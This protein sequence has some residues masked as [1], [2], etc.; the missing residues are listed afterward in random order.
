MEPM[1]F[2][3]ILL[4]SNEYVFFYFFFRAGTYRMLIFVHIKANLALSNKHSYL[5]N[6]P[7]KW[8]DLWYIYLHTWFI[9]MVNVR[10]LG[11]S[12]IYTW[13]LRIIFQSPVMGFRFFF[14]SGFF[15]PSGFR[16]SF[17]CKLWAQSG[18]EGPQTLLESFE[19]GLGPNKY[20]LYKD[21]QAV[22]VPSQGF[23][24]HFPGS[25]GSGVVA[26]FEHCHGSQ[27]GF[28]KTVEPSGG[29]KKKMSNVKCHGKCL[30]KNA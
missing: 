29:R 16:E 4:G 2:I 12:R 17:C 6:A 24:H 22:W 7:L 23:S 11:I 18:D 21:I 10:R 15:R 28:V 9:F 27:G 8:A 25:G 19:S 5:N 26:Y 30:I 20:S 13:I 3:Y 1:G 14:S